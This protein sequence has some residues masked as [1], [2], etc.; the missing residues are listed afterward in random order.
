MGILSIYPTLSGMNTKIL[1][2]AAGAAA[3]SACTPKSTEPEWEFP[4]VERARPAAQPPK[5]ATPRT[6]PAPGEDPFRVP[7]VTD[8]LPNHRSGTT[9]V[10]PRAALPGD[11][12]LAEIPDTPPPTAVEAPTDESVPAEAP[13]PPPQG[14]Q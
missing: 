4:L 8:Q 6:V 11:D 5:P 13:T 9:P 3:L 14:Q 1:L 7:D 10:T 12:P 2:A